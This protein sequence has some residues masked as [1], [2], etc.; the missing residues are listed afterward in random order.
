MSLK[1]SGQQQTCG[2]CH[3]TPKYCKG[4]GIARKC[5]DE[6]GDRVDFTDYI[7]KLWKEIG[8]SPNSE[9]LNAEMNSDDDATEETVEQFTPVK[10]PSAEVE[11]F[12]GVTISRYPKGMDNGQIIEMLC[13]C[14]LSEDKKDNIIIKLNGN[15][16]VKNLDTEECRFL[17]DAIHGQR[18]FDRKFYCNGIVPLTPEKHSETD[19]S[20]VQ[21]TASTT[22]NGAPP[23]Q[24]SNTSGGPPSSPA[25][26]PAIDLSS[27][28]LK[29]LPHA[30]SESVQEKTST[31]AQGAPPASSA[32]AS[33][34]PLSLPAALS[35]IDIK[36]LC[37]PLTDFNSCVS[38]TE[39]SSDNADN[40]DEESGNKFETMNEKKR[41]KRNKRKNSL[42]PN[43]DSFLKKK[44]SA[45]DSAC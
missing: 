43:K 19:N 36:N 11:S 25:K 21:D 40:E 8:Y 5:Q 35:P 30:A 7:V 33:G 42:T 17:I 26:T 3:N 41:A 15:V 1:Y 32:T 38:S 31:T 34:G 23:V 39:E 4:G 28:A 37:E 16:T 24:S 9:E 14:G 12:S 10:I 45:I 6:G 27:T 2:R 13:R 22:A 20:N 44:N 29:D 18:F